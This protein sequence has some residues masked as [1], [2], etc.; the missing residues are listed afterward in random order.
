MIHGDSVDKKAFVPQVRDLRRFFQAEAAEND[1]VHLTS[2]ER[3][4]RIGLLTSIPF[5][6]AHR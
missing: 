1:G 2:I 6:G 3:V 5:T 4:D